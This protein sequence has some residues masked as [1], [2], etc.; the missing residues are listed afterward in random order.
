LLYAHT[1]NEAQLGPSPL[2]AL[3]F[4]SGNVFV[5]ANNPYNPFGID[6]GA[7]D[8][9]NLGSQSPRVRARFVDNGNR[10]FTSETDA[11]RL[12]GG[13]KGEVS[14]GYNWDAAATYSRQDQTFTIDNAIDIAALNQALIPNG[15]VNGAGL[16]LSLLNDVA[17]NPLPVYNIFAL[18][19]NDPA[20]VNAITATGVEEGTSELFSVDG[21]VTGEVF[22][23]LPSGSRISF[24]A[25]GQYVLESLSISVNEV[26]QQGLPGL[27][28]MQ[29]F[30]SHD[31]DREAA[32]L[33]VHFPLVSA[34]NQ[35]PGCYRLDLTAAGRFEQI[36]PGGSKAVPKVG[37]RWQPLDEQLTL[38]GGYSQ[39]FVA[40]A[41]YN[42]YGPDS[43]SAAVVTLSDGVGQVT[44]VTRG[45]P[46]LRP[47]ESEQWNGGLV[48]TPKI[49]PRFTVSADFYHVEINHVADADYTSAASSLNA[50]GSASPHAP[51]FT[52]VNGTQLTTTDPNQVTIA[53]WG[54]LTLPFTDTGVTRTEGLDFTLLYG[55]PLPEEW[56]NSTFIGNANW[57]LSYEYQS[58]PGA[59]FYSYEGQ[60]TY[61]FGTAQGLIPDYRLNC[62][63]S[64]GFKDFNYTVAA[65]FIPSVEIPGYL[66]PA[67]VD[68]NAPAQGSTLDDRAQ[69]LE[70][71]YTID[72]QIS[73]EIGRGRRLQ[74]WYD[75]FRFTVGCNNI[76]DNGAP[77]IAGADEDNTDKNYYDLLGRFVYLE[78]SKKF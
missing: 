30:P 56:G 38:R 43:T 37:L 17:G 66:H 13:F 71:Y 12:V 61:G 62:G 40:P 4:A 28:A 59:P 27:S 67:V 58:A 70:S 5:P 14:P 3:A 60:G 75:G 18:S 41:L 64:W 44:V 52:F 45:N 34:E 19:G 55:L 68:P 31:R 22:G 42:L 49:L 9:G 78:I 32:F 23:E 54:S 21:K 47:S 24:A 20:T 51:G 77:L 76:T 25:G 8:L 63:L 73:Y 11:Y 39:G 33:E 16:P 57:V 15:Q 46:Q 65:H 72:M 53:N 48:L 36:N 74:R 29:P 50:L 10:I 69:Q 1:E 35:L 6:L 26:W 7:D 2:P